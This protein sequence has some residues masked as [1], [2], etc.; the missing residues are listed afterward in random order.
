MNC[1][2]EAIDLLPEAKDLFPEAIDLFP[3]AKDLFPEAID[4][5]PEAKDL[6]PEAI[7]LFPEAIDWLRKAMNAPKL[8]GYRAGKVCLHS[9]PHELDPDEGN[10]SLDTATP[11]DRSGVRNA[12]GPPAGPLPARLAGPA[13]VLLVDDESPAS[14]RRSRRRAGGATCVALSSLRPQHTL[15]VDGPLQAHALGG[16]GVEG[17]DGGGALVVDGDRSAA[18]LLLRLDLVL[19]HACRDPPEGDVE[20]EV[21]RPLGRFLGVGH[22][23]LEAVQL[24]RIV[25]PHQREL[26]PPRLLPGHPGRAAAAIGGPVIRPGMRSPGDDDVHGLLDVGGEH[27]R[28][29]EDEKQS[30]TAKQTIHESPLFSAAWPRCRL[31]AAFAAFQILVVIVPAFRVAPNDDVRKSTGALQG[32]VARFSVIPSAAEP[33]SARLRSLRAGSGVEHGEEFPPWNPGVGA[34]SN[35]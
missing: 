25:L 16:R 30:Q 27:R 29:G 5:F 9:A 20:E 7:D 13:A 6:P 24:L 28:R 17:D 11:T 23:E 32:W 3:E 21:V 26:I 4:L 18:A 35:P 10:D 22:D 19:G 12:G 8:V 1:L 2:P 15:A 14:R 31:S 33:P 34:M